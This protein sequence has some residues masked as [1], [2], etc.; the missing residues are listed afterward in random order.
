LSPAEDGNRSN[1]RE[2]NKD[3][4]HSSL[5]GSVIRSV[6]KLERMIE[7]VHQNSTYKVDYD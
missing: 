4:S 3:T 7:A 2:L 6:V 1:N 5:G